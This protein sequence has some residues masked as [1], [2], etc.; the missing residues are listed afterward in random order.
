MVAEAS[1]TSSIEDN[2]IQTQ[3]ANSNKINTKY[4]DM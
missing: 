2:F 3:N 1:Y 4:F